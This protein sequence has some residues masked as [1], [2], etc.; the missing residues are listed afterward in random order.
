M[1]AL[2]TPAAGRCVLVS[3]ALV[4]QQPRA[5][6]AARARRVDRPDRSPRSRSRR[7]DSWPTYNGDYSGR[8][9]SSADEDQRGQ[10]QE[11]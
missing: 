2:G 9:F 8:R 5:G 4:A 7:T 10:R 3:A 1:R 6:A 11:L